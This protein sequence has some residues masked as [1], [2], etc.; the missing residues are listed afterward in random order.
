[1]NDCRESEEREI[2]ESEERVWENKADNFFNEGVVVGRLQCEEL[3]AVVDRFK[4]V[5]AELPGRARNYE[6]ELE[7]RE[8][9]PFMQRR[10]CLVYTSRWV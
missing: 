6:C 9:T 3:W 10:Y 8:H 5:F 4:E 2:D 1:M 7:V